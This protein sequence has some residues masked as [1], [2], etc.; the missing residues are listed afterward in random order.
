MTW[1]LAAMAG[2]FAFAA[3]NVEIQGLT[4]HYAGYGTTEFLVV[5]ISSQRLCHFR[6]GNLRK[7]YPVSTSRFGIGSVAG[8]NRTPLGMHY[9]RRRIGGDA[10]SGSIFRGRVN[11]GKIASIEGRPRATGKDYVTS[12]IMWLSGL[13]Q[14]LNKGPG[15]DSYSRYIYIHGT[16]EEGLIGRP[17]SHGCIRMRNA[18]VIEL[19][20][21]I[22]LKT[23]VWIEQ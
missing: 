2:S 19:F 1:M 16:H 9:V 5:D 3:E 10:S 15:V 14:G 4:Q 17:A 7:C 11:I 23:L 8:S 21:Q 6:H 13:D 18:D 20:D 12:R 22:P